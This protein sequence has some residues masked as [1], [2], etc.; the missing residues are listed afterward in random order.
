M[1]KQGVIYLILSC[2]I[3]LFARYAHILIV[4]IDMFYT[5]INVKLAPI[6]SNSVEGVL[7]RDVIT[8]VLLPIFIVAI[9]ALIY[10]LFKGQQMPY[11]IEAT[12]FLWLII[13][14]SKVL[15]H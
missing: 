9:P 6:F 2:L 12:W 8:L 4:Y 1:L 14:L 3:V 10:R 11:F 15:I 7:I 13:V 5:L